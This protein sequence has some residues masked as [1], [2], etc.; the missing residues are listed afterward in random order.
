MV[1][2]HFYISELLDK[3]MGQLWIVASVIPVGVV[4]YSTIVYI[5]NVVFCGVILAGSSV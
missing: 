1:V 3:L 5:E 2:W 4:F